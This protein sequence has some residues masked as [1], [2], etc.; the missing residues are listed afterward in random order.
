[1]PAGSR[2]HRHP[3]FPDPDETDLGHLALAVLCGDGSYDSQRNDRPASTPEQ[4]GTAEMTR[5]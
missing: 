3:R 4:T 1:M 5:V 2:Y